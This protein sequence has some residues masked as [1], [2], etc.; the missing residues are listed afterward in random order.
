MQLQAYG[1]ASPSYGGKGRG[2]AVLRV[3]KTSGAEA[4]DQFYNGNPAAF[5]TGRDWMTKGSLTDAARE[6][7]RAG[8]LKG[9][10]A[11]DLATD[12]WT[13]G[14]DGPT[15]ARVMR[16]AY[17]HA[18]DIAL[19]GGKR[20]ETFIVTGASGRFH[21][22]VCDGSAAVSV[23]IVRPDDHEGS[24]RAH[25]RTW[26]FRTDNEGEVRDQSVVDFEDP[27]VL[28]GRVSGT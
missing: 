17:E 18:I 12:T 1:S 13:G 8:K 6:M 5:N 26:V 22:Q 20:L 10:N 15:V 7:E 3:Y 4:L 2:H 16:K 25:A 14:A 24:R 21:V 11:D 9:G 19:Q 28:R 27:P 23:F